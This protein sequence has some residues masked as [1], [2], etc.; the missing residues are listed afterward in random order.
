[1]AGTE[2]PIFDPVAFDRTFNV[3][4]PVAVIAHLRTIADDGEVLSRDLRKAIQSGA[5]DAPVVA[6]ALG[7][8]IEVTLPAPRELI[9]STVAV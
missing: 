5:A 6:D 7:A 3:L 1:M 9:A 2:L 4:A 8:T